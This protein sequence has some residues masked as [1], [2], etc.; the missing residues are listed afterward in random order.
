M[1]AS[2]ALLAVKVAIVLS[3]YCFQVQVNIVNRKQSYQMEVALP[4][5]VQVV[6]VF[7]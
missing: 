7:F 6:L 4:G 5:G 2:F 3:R 1:V